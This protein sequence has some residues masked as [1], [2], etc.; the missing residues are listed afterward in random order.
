MD[1]GSM[2][3]LESAAFRRLVSHLDARKDVQ[4]IE[5]MTMAGFCRNCLSRWLREAADE[6]GVPLDDEAAREHVYGMPYADWKK[7]YQSP[8]TPEQIEAFKAA[9]K[10]D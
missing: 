3:A 1:E 10:A 7:A 8:A 9:Q 4:N 2:A 6:L 5:L